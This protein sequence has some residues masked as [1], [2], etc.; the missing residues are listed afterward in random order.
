MQ[1]WRC[2][3]PRTGALRSTSASMWSRSVWP[4]IAKVAFEAAR[5]RRGR[6]TVAGKRHVLPMTEGLFFKAIGLEAVLHP[7]V[8]WREMDIDAMAADLYTRP[9]D[10][11]VILTTN[12]FGDVLSN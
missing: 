7:N 10:H 2:W 9:G 4:R 3:R 6:I 5:H 11:D 12:L 1:H 8:S